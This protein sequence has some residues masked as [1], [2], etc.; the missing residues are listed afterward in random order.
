MRHFLDRHILFFGGK[1][2]VGKTTCSSALA[3]AASRAGKR[4]LL[5]S[6]DPAHSTSDIFERSFGADEREVLPGLTGLEIDAETEAR[7]YLDEAKRR[8]AGLFSPPVVSAAA[9]QLELTASMPGLADVALFER[10]ADLIVSR[11]ETYDLVVFDTAPTGHALRLLRMP[12]LMATWVDALR[13][14]RRDATAASSAAEERP[15]RSDAGAADPVLEILEARAARLD[16]VRRLSRSDRVGFVLVLVPERL[17]IDESVRAV[18]HIQDTG[19]KM[20]GVVI[21]RVLPE[22]ASGEYFRARKAQE[23]VHLAEIERRFAGVPRVVVPQLDADVHG[24]A[25]LERVSGYLLAEGGAAD[26]PSTRLR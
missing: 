14:R 17:P 25:S 6:T 1:G 23:R 18:H 3:L 7:R 26:H 24:L 4:V 11:G 20:C 15:T 9:R 2:G 8:M 21:N 16:A 12:E 13:R 19:V 10:M 5:V 22:E